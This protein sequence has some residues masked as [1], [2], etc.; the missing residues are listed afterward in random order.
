MTRMLH[1]LG[2]Q[3]VVRLERLEHRHAG[4]DDRGHVACRSA[5]GPSSP[6]IGNVSSGP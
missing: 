4:A 3:L 6:P 5:A 1:A 2:L